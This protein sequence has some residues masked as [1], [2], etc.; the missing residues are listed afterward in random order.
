MIKLGTNYGGWFIPSINTLSSD[1]IIIS[2]GVG[3]DISFDLHINHLYRS[4]IILIDP[5]NKA[6]KH[7]NEISNKNELTGNI[8]SDY[9]ENIKNLDVDFSKFI[10]IP[11]GL[12]IENTKLKFYKQSNPLYVSQSF[13]ENMFSTEYDIVDTITFNQ[14]IEL[15]GSK[16]DLLKLDI[17]GAEVSVLNQ[18]L[19]LE[20]YPKYLLVEFDLYLKKKDKSNETNKL[21]E[22]IKEKYNLLIND[23]FNI[24]FELKH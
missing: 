19:D 15:Y 16:I 22:R 8:Q 11:K 2:V 23:N 18:M 5:T 4:K 3:E 6:I 12:W 20:I 1:S 17:E 13:I 7:F 9:L 21:I 14:L 10:Y 24:T